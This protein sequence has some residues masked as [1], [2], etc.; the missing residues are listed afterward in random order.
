MFSDRYSCCDLII[1]GD[2]NC[3]LDCSS[4][5]VSPKL[6]NLIS[7]YM[8]QRCDVLFPGPSSATYIN[9]ALNQHSYIDYIRTT[10]QNVYNFAVLG[11]DANFSDHLPL[12]V[13]SAI[14]IKSCD[15]SS[16]NIDR[17][18]ISSVGQS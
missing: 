2:F 5:P 8:L 6:S 14:L 1:A 9:E 7:H 10:C 16:M 4:D 3:C 18:C 15:H 12:F 11:P 13:M 17:C